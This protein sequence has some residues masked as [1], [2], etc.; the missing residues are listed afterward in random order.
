[1]K[2]NQR[3]MDRLKWEYE[4]EM[5]VRNEVAELNNKFKTEN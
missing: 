2:D 3:K 1:L 5:R 4:E